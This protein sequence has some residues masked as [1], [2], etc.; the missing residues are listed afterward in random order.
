ML[1]IGE[2]L[3]A[4]DDFIDLRK[5]AV[6]HGRKR[7]PGSQEHNRIHHLV[8]IEVYKVR[9]GFRGGGTAWIGWIRVQKADFNHENSSFPGA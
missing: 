1:K 3:L 9:R 6:E 7:V 4:I 2:D 8:E 5:R